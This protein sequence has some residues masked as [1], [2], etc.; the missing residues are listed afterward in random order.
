MKICLEDYEDSSQRCLI[1]GDSVLSQIRSVAFSERD[2]SC[3]PRGYY[4]ERNIGLFTRNKC[5][6]CVYVENEVLKMVLLGNVYNLLEDGIRAESEVV[7]LFA[8][9]FTLFR[10]NNILLSF[11]YWFY[12]SNDF[13]PERDIFLF[14][15]RITRSPVTKRRFLAILSEQ[16]S[17][18]DV[19]RKDF[20]DRLK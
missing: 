20:V 6:V 10:G 9:R 5:A 7:F 18:R 16:A 11:R 3:M 2:P 1:D 8:R 19:T 4:S 15:E 14:I 12:E 17:G 13:W